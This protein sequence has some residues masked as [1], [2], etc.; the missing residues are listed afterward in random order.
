MRLL[1]D[2]HTN[3]LNEKIVLTAEDEADK[4]GSHHQYKID[5]EIPGGRGTVALNFQ[6]GPIK[7]SGYNGI[8]QEVLLAVVI[9]RLKGFQKS[10]FSCKENACALTHLEEALMWLN[11][12]TGDRLKRGVEGTLNK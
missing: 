4:N 10:Q 8:T 2:H 9:D 7:E 6:K 12:R 1:T 11:K 3:E 5:Y